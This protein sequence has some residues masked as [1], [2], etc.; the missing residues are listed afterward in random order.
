[1]T[2]PTNIDPKDIQAHF[3]KYQSDKYVE[4]WASSGTKAI[5]CD[6]LVQR[7]GTIGRPITQDGE[8]R[9]ALVPDC[10][11][12]VDV[13]LFV[14]FGYDA[15]SLQCSAA[16]VEACKKEEKENHSCYTALRH[17]KLLAS[18]PAGN[19][20]CLESPY[21]KDPLAPGPPFAHPGEKISYNNKGLVDA[22]LLREPSKAG[23]ERV[24]Y[25][26]PERTHTVCKDKNGVIHD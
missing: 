6:T 9:K 8:R 12:G 11:R 5:A 20:I 19:L 2:T 18:L 4:G 15:Y 1:M 21:H 24:V 16:A 23:L 17:T 7:D 25:W 13:L 26:Q 14:S 10:V 3:A 22:D